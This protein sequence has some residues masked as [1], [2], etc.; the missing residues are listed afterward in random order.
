MGEVRILR[1]KFI[2][3]LYV[4]RCRLKSVFKSF[5]VLSLVK[6]VLLFFVC[7][8]MLDVFCVVVGGELNVVIFLV[9]RGV[10]G[11]FLKEYLCWKRFWLLC[12][13]ME[14]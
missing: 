14:G 5:F 6:I 12:Y 4:I 3:G 10:F 1:F 11:K 7:G 8:R 2:I 9:K 13:V